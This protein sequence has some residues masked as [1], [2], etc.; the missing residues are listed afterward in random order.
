MPGMA[1]LFNHPTFHPYIIVLEAKPLPSEAVW[2]LCKSRLQ[3][4][5]MFPQYDILRAKLEGA[6][7]ETGAPNENDTRLMWKIMID[8]IS[9]AR[10]PFQ[11]KKKLG[12][13]EE[14][15][16]EACRFG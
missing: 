14:L 7:V 6:E 9:A 4:V 3:Y 13:T 12:K 1:Y 11:P 5:L 8:Q 16:E 10:G 2:S 15:V